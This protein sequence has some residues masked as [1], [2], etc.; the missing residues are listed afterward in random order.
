MRVKRIFNC[1]CIIIFIAEFSFAGGIVPPKQ[2]PNNPQYVKGEILVKF[3]DETQ[4]HQTL[5]KGVQQTGISAIDQLKQTYQ[6]EKM[7]KV[8]KNAKPHLTKPTFKDYTGKIHEVPNLD[9]IYKINYKDKIDPVE[10][11]K[12]YEEVSSVE[13]AEPNY[14]SKICVEPNDPAFSQQWGLH[15]IGQ[16]HLEDADIDA[17]EAWDIESGDSTIIIGIID[18][19]VDWGHPD[20]ADKMVSTGY[21]FV[22]NDN[23]AM[24]DNGHGTHVAGIAAATTNNT[25][26][27]AGVAWKCKV[28]PVKVLQSNGEG[29]YS[30]IAAGIT[31][32]A[33]NGAKIIN[34]SLGGYAES[35]TLRDALENA[36]STAVIVSS[37]GNDKTEIPFYP[38]AY[39]F[40]VGVGASDVL[41][42]RQT[43]TWYEGVALFS[44]I[45][46]NADLYAPGVNI[47]ST[48]PLFHP[49]SYSYTS[50]NGTSMAAPFVS[51]TVALIRSH[52]PDWSN[53]LIHG[54]LIN[55]SDPISGGIRLNAHN[56]LIDVA[57]PQLSLYSHTII[58]TLPGDD[59]DGI[60]DAGETVE[61]IFEIQ[62]TWG[63]AD[64]VKAILKPHSYEDTMFITILDSTATFGT[65]S[66]YAHVTNNT[67][68]FV[69]SL[70]SSTPNNIDI[71]FDYEITCDNGGPFT[72]TFYITAQ[73][74][75]E[76]G[77]VLSG[78]TIWSN[79]YLY[80]VTSNTL[81]QEEDT[82]T[83]EPGTRIQ[84]D[85][86]RYLRIDGCL[87]AIG[88]EDSMIVFTSN[89][90][91]PTAGDWEGIRFTDKSVDAEFDTNDNYVS[92]S[93]IKH[94]RIE[95]C[96]PGLLIYDASPYI[97]SNVFQDITHEGIDISRSETL[98]EYNLI[99]N[100]SLGANNF[101]GQIFGNIIEDNL[102]G[103]GMYVNGGS[104]IGNIMRCNHSGGI[105][106]TNGF[107]SNN[108]IC[109]NNGYYFGAVNFGYDVNS[110]TYFKN[111]TIMSNEG[112]IS[113]YYTVGILDSNNIINNI[114]SSS[115]FEFQ[116][117]S[118]TD[119]YAQNNY[120]GTTNTDSIDTWI[121][122]YFDDF[123]LGKV[124]YQPFETTPI[125][126]APGFLYKV[127]FNPPSP[128]GCEIDTFTLIFSKP[129]DISIQPYVT[130]GVCEPYTQ[131]I[132]E[133]D[134]IDSIHWQGNYVFNI[135]T[136]DGINHLR[137][138]TAKD[139]EGM[140]IPKDTRFI[141]VVDAAG[142]SS[143]GFIAQAGDDKV[144][145]EWTKPEMVDLMGYNM[146][147]YYQLTDTTFSDT[148]L[149]NTSMIT[150]TTYTDYEAENGVTYF[151]MYTAISTDFNES[152][153]SKSASATP[154]EGLGSDDEDLKIPKD[155]FLAQNYPNPFNPTTT[156]TYSIPTQSNV[157]IRIYDLLGKEV[158]TL[159]SEKQEAKH[160]KVIWDA[161]DRSGN[162][163]P[164]GMYFYRIVAKSRDRI[165][166]KTKKLLLLR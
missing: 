29:S 2:D 100:C 161:K 94:A 53:E 121:W 13:Y 73:R 132:I 48:I 17:P 160:Y 24:D 15:N 57:E 3:K 123:D 138:T 139:C 133:G 72:G 159:V 78:N 150:D 90:L 117:L 8:F 65:A 166:A 75:I 106:I 91:N 32:A 61:M 25:T 144:H 5:A 77:G 147:R 4:I 107:I 148:I 28:L 41:Y 38:A 47:Y 27:I 83:I 86:D 64:N 143:I 37:A 62:N 125:V 39:S 44:N 153:F 108:S 76:V 114:Q 137:A 66:P 89:A 115:Q 84:F 34:L 120:W 158:V 52:S 110:N 55:T 33:N 98:L 136:G 80:V 42:N 26:G 162:T 87:M 130:F 82:L 146:Y 135:M 118:C 102:S 81:V 154:M 22:N 23:D 69:F 155:Y 7:E 85:S 10:L 126:D 157:E 101:N 95:L 46:L 19:G 18:T 145:L 122:D 11:S 88:T 50:W 31:Y 36:Y 149:I 35:F 140:E 12:K 142:A 116:K 129:M 99:R 59:S 68:P 92:G 124:I 49:H 30:D 93:I 156:I 164:S 111:N 163:V 71:Y 74:G 16:Y 127:E 134:W 105:N 97:T 79:N 104:V 128:I 151:Y 21:D 119:I 152:Y 56:S 70:N 112:G 20:L 131:H 9:K 40:V 1:L 141:F 103:I 43:Q 113:S 58:D 165:F 6:V 51:G 14:I 45:G 54:Q 109:H 96:G 67:S 63:Q 60:A